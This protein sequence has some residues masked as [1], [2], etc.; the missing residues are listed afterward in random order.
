LLIM[1]NRR[2]ICKFVSERKL[3]TH[4]KDFTERSKILLD[5]DLKIIFV[6]TLKIMSNAKKC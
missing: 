2:T 4:R 6:G 3:K 5:T 1:Q